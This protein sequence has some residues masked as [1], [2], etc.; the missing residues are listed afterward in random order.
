MTPLVLLPGLGLDG[1]LYAAQIR[2][3]A[4]VA[5]MTVGDTLH[6][7]SLPAMATR[8]LAAAPDRFALAGLSMGGYL[9]F[10]ILRQAPERVT[11][12]ALLDTS[13]RA[14]TPEA[15]QGRH[16]AIAAVAKHPYRA[17]AVASLARLVAP[18]ASQ[19]VRDQ[20]VDMSVRVGPDA[21]VRQQRA[22]MAR[23]D[24]R[25]LL[26]EIRV[27]TLVLVGDED[28]LTPPALAEEMAGA[29][30]QATLVRVPGSGHLSP[31]EAPA[32]VTAALRAWLPK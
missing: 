18:S 4:D 30:P 25:P 26:P 2:D 19:I 1:G 12:L 10:E 24:S 15:T 14:D 9:A 7:D 16:D 23:P 28:V 6:D 32:A 31:L 22:I 11:R 21:Y 5:A 20:V 27:P 17:L 13:A 3:L 8:V 29:I